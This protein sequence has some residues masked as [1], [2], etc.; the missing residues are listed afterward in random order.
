[1][2]YRLL[3]GGRWTT[4]IRNHCL[5]K[6]KTMQEKSRES[7]LPDQLLRAGEVAI[8]LNISRAFAY[9]LMSQ[10]ILPTVMIGTARRV[11]PQDLHTY[12]EENIYLN[13]KE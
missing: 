8:V 7:E 11:R 6:D 2:F 5:I 9:Q 1:M 4:Q 3:F 10:G 12:I 13:S